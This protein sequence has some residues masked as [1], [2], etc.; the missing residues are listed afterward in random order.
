VSVRGGPRFNIISLIEQGN[1]GVKG[2]GLESDNQIEV[3]RVSKEYR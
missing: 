3:Y 2:G 1:S